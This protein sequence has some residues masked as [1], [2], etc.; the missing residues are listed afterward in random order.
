[1]IKSRK[2]FLLDFLENHPYEQVEPVWKSYC[3]FYRFLPILFI[4]I[5][6][7]DILVY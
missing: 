4:I 3:K 2:S 6:V 1:M 7:N 5:F